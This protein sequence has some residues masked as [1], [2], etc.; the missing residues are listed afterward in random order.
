MVAQNSANTIVETIRQNGQF[1]SDEDQA[2]VEAWQQGRA[3]ATIFG[4]E[5]WDILLELHQR[6]FQAKLKEHFDLP[7][8]SPA[9][10]ASHAAVKA[11]NEMITFVYQEATELVNKSHEL[12]LVVKQ[13]LR[14]AGGAPAESL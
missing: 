9:A 12:P 14:G 6:Y 13:G 1:V 7:D 10:V 2:A 11:I 3:L 5:G 4:T 8:G